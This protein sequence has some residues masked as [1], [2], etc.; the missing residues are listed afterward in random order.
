VSVL[1]T[2]KSNEYTLSKEV[3][4]S[5]G[6]SLLSMPSGQDV[7]DAV[8]CVVGAEDGLDVGSLVGEGEG[9]SVGG[10]EGLVVGALDGE[11][12]RG[13]GEGSAL[14]DLDGG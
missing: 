12:V 5:P 8:G 7:G 14:G 3:H 4:S 11:L 6:I 1:A 9:L 2:S 13:L 10:V